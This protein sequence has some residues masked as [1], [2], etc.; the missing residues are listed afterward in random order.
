MSLSMLPRWEV[1]KKGEDAF[2]A[3]DIG[4]ADAKEAA[5]I[6]AAELD[7]RDISCAMSGVELVVRDAAGNETTVF[8]SGTWEIE[9][10]A[11]EKKA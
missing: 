11:R 2:S 9:W 4:A 6:W 1:W 8:V 7:A 3:F 10:D 5:I